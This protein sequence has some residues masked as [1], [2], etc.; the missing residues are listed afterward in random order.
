MKAVNI[1]AMS[2]ECNAADRT[3]RSALKQHLKKGEDKLLTAAADKRAG[4]KEG[5]NY[6]RL[7]T[8]QWL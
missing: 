7:E 4:R 6:I 1:D 5:S 8:T 2:W 3:R